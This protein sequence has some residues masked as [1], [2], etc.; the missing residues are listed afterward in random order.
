MF[1]RDESRAGVEATTR[2]ARE[3]A[4][5][6]A[7]G[8]QTRAAFTIAF[9]LYDLMPNTPLVERL[10]A[11]LQAV[12]VPAWTEDEHAFAQECQRNFGVPELGMIPQPLPLIP[13]RAEGDRP[14]SVT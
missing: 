5:G 4:D 7:L 6:A 9:G 2:W 10:F 12:G 3:L 8:T 13:D 11:H 1:I 14:M